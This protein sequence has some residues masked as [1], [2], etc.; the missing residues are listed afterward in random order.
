MTHRFT[1]KTV[2]N[3]IG[4]DVG[5]DDARI[6]ESGVL[7]FII[8]NKVQVAYAANYWTTFEYDYEETE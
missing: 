2:E 8:D 7:A 3:T 1:V 4:D 5:A 6:L